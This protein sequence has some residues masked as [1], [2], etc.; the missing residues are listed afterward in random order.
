VR[1]PAVL[2]AAWA[3][4]GIVAVLLASAAVGR[5]GN[6]V[7]GSRPAPLSAADVQA[8][9]AAESSTSVPTSSTSS[10]TSEASPGEP[11]GPTETRTYQ[12]VGGTAT[13][14]F[15]PAGVTVVSATP[16]PGFAVEVEPQGN[17][18]EVSFR[19]GSHRSKVEA[20]WSA[21][22]HDEVEEE[23]EDD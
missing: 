8:E 9:L 17:G 4:A 5:V 10:T 3:L 2:V 21:G 22:P 1:R 14:R 20:Q 13:L 11:S 6:E 16:N 18:V 19:S 23:P 15:Q 12:L 7:T